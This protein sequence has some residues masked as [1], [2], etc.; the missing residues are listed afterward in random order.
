MTNAFGAGALFE[1]LQDKVERFL[2]GPPPNRPTKP[3]VSVTE[4]PTTPAPTAAP[5]PRVSLPPG[6]SPRPTPTPTPT[7]ARRPVDVDI[8]RDPESFFAH[9]LEDDWCAVAGTQMVIA[10]HRRGNTG[11]G[12][13]REIASRIREWESWQDSHNGNWGPAAIVEAL[14]EYGVPGYE[15]RAYERRSTALRD[16]ARQI[17]KTGAPVVLLAWKGAHTWIMTGYRADADPLVFRDAHVSGA[18]ILDPWYPWD[19]SIWGPSDPP[20]T[21][22]DEAEMERNFLR[23]ERPEGDYPDRDGKY[24]TIVPTVPITPPG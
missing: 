22:Q 1:R 20:G 19:S 16:A 23:W 18:Y 12:F 4:P 3:T 6:A 17:S 9:E 21:F 15:I 10:I 2:A 5:T 14:A 13:Q 7:P 24:I 11:E 8:L